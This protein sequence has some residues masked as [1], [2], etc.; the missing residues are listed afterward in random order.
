[1]KILS[2]SLRVLARVLTLLIGFL[3]EKHIN[4]SPTIVFR[5][6]SDCQKFAQFYRP[7]TIAVSGSGFRSVPPGGVAEA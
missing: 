4:I 2:R 5:L 1:M 6:K 7:L 3:K